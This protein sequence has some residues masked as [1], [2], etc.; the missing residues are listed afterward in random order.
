MCFLAISSH[1]FYF[2]D[3]HQK[4]KSADLAIRLVIFDYG[5]GQDLFCKPCRHRVVSLAALQQDCNQRKLTI[6]FKYTCIR[7]RLEVGLEFHDRR[8]S[9]TRGLSNGG[10]DRCSH[11]VHL[12]EKALMFSRDLL[13][14]P[15][16]I[17]VFLASS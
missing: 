7:E 10:L 4:A 13:G 6:S 1:R 3:W 16:R 14:K 2:N 5:L 17:Q 9:D 11:S 15:I 8:L 12:E